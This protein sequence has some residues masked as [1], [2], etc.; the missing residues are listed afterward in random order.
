MISKTGSAVWQ[1]DLRDGSGVVSSQSGTLSNVDYSFAKRFEGEAG[2][3]PEELLAAAHAA[4]YSMAFSNILAGHDLTARRIE[5]EAEVTLDPESLSIVKVHL[6]VTA[7]VPGATEETF[8]EAANAA[9]EGCP[10]SKLFD[11]EITLAA[12]LTS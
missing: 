6:D 3:N 4:C 2:T 12:H 9:K 10:V 8:K 7:T 1:G 5:T 11:T